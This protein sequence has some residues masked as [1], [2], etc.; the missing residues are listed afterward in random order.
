MVG[1]D[2]AGMQGLLGHEKHVNLLPQSIEKPLGKAVRIRFIFLKCV[3]IVQEWVGGMLSY[4][5]SE[6][7][8]LREDKRRTQVRRKLLMTARQVAELI[9]KSQSSEQGFYNYN[10]Y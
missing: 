5:A 4:A 3:S 6:T 9:S 1:P 7:Q 10:D 2:Y 8:Q